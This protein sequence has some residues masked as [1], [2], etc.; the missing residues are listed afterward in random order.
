MS[1]AYLA[2]ERSIKD[3]ED[4]LNRFDQDK[5]AEVLK[6]AGII[7]ALAAWETYVKDRIR[8][9]FD[10]QLKIVEKS[11]IGN[12]VRQ[13]LE[14]DMKRFYNPNSEKTRKIF[15]NYFE[16]DITEGWAWGS[17]KPDEAKKNLDKFI[18]MR[19]DAAHRANTSQKPSIV[20]HLVKREDLDKA[21]RFFKGI[22]KATDS[23]R[24]AK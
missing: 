8:E 6:R 4:L 19:G 9:E 21:I 7:M 10:V 5:E 11:F 16:V 1:E 20:P 15:I 3:A 17:Y 2:F 22:V 23:V 12:F 13:R 18:A 14:E 24:L